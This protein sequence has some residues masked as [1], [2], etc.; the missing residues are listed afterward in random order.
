V[1]ERIRPYVVSD[2][3]ALIK[4]HER[5]LLDAAAATPLVSR[6]VQAFY[7]S[8]LFDNPW[9]ASD[10][11]SLV[12]EGREGEIAAFVGVLP[13]WMTF[14]DRPVRVAVLTRVMADPEHPKGS[15]GVAALFK[16]A[17]RGPQDLS[18]GDVVNEPG[19]RLWEAS[20]GYVVAVSSLW[21][22]SPTNVDAVELPQ[23]A[24]HQM[25]VA[26]LLDAIE[27][28]SKGYALR[29][30]YDERSL[31]WLL[32]H[33]DGAGHRGT[34]HRRAVVAPGGGRAGWYLYYSN[35]EGFNGVQQV[36]VVRG[37]AADLVVADMLAHA[38]AVSGA[39]ETRG[40]AELGLA[41]ALRAMGCD[42]HFGPWTYAHSQD[43]DLLL[44]LTT[45]QAFLTR[46]EGEI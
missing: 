10:L 21:W 15:I 36:G 41:G 8:V 9:A 29:P 26:E 17:L 40:R 13:R 4:L 16:H 25:E 34:L 11:P 3:P 32:K 37:A 30:I 39:A 22:S 28:A 14:R 43:R 6:F 18:L 38:T 33:L 5:T 42:L 31:A 2:A 27:A 20:K 12:Y 23:P 7:K 1:A 24:G 46:L 44:A 35:P 19:R 45:G